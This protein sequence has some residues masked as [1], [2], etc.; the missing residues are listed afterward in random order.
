MGEPLILGE[1]R[2]DI[3]GRV[4]IALLQVKN[5]RRLTY[6]EMAA[7]MERT[8]ESIGKYILGHT[9]MGIVAFA[10]ALNAWPEL[11]DKLIGGG[12]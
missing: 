2:N 1:T 11:A 3:L 5:A 4:G 8:D 7:V 10:L 9:E 6:D 12:K